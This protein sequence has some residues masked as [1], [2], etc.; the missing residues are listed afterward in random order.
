MSNETALAGGTDV[1]RVKW[2][3]AKMTTPEKVT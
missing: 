3:L 2:A 1:A